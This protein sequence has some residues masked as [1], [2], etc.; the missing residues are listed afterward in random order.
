VILQWAAMIEA[1][2]AMRKA[3]ESGGFE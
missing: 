1:P 3:K 2:L